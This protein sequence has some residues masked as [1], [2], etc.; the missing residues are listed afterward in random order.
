MGFMPIISLCD[1]TVSFEYRRG[2]PEHEVRCA[3]DSRHGD[4]A[5]LGLFSMRPARPQLS[6]GST[7]SAMPPPHSVNSPKGVSEARSSSA[8]LVVIRDAPPGVRELAVVA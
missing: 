6:T 1:N 3:N 5:D 8:M 7:R 2:I 4:L